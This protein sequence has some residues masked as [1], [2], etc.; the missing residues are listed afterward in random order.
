[1]FFSASHLLT[2]FPRVAGYAFLSAVRFSS[3]FYR[4]KRS[5]LGNLTFNSCNAEIKSNLMHTD[6]S[7]T[8]FGSV[9]HRSVIN[10]Q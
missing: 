5:F 1:M 9:Q 6:E 2:S 3:A 7:K 8:G 4:Q 10:E